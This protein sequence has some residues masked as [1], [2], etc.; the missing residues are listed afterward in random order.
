MAN[1]IAI[2]IIFAQL[3]NEPINIQCTV[4]DSISRNSIPLVHVTFE[5][6]GKSFNTRQSSFY[7]SLPSTTYSIILE[8]DA[9]EKCVKSINVSLENNS[10][11][12]EMVKVT[13]RRWLRARQDTLNIYLDSLDSALERRNFSAAKRLIIVIENFNCSEY[14]LDSIYKSYDLTKTTWADSILLIAQELEDS[15][16]YADAYFYYKKI[17]DI[18]SLNETA[19]LKFDEIDKKI[20]G[21][22]ENDTLHVSEVTPTL[23]HKAIE[24]MYNEALAKFFSQDYKGARKLFNTILRYNP[25]HKG[26]QKYLKKTK[27]RLKILEKE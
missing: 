11:V 9:Y 10:F 12:F 23:T 17:I 7:V 8:A 18:D 16:K 19:L 21:V 20:A 1:F 2:L 26:A 4:R 3:N 15:T 5:N 25:V 27:A 22:Q 24:K 13:D 14:V 6:L